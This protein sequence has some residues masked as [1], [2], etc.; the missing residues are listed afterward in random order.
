MTGKAADTDAGPI[1]LVSGAV[2]NL[3]H[4]VAAAQ[5]G[6]LHA[7][8]LDHANQDH[9]DRDHQQGMDQPAHGV[10]GHEAEQPEDDKDD[11]NGF[12]HDSSPGAD[13]MGF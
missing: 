3:G 8:A 6:A 13:W 11:C 10:R 7:S 12:E 4:T 1:V 9:H 2:G 5:A